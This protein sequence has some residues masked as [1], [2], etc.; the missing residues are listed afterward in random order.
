[1]DHVMST[2]G[3]IRLS[4]DTEVSSDDLKCLTKTLDPK[5]KLI[6]NIENQTIY[7]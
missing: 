4:Q 7:S 1:M 3:R 6:A 5:G 2:N